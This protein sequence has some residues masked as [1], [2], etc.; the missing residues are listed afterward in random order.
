MSP[1]LSFIKVTKQKVQVTLTLVKQFCKA[2]VPP[3]CEYAA[4]AHVVDLMN[5][6]SCWNFIQS[7]GIIT[8][9]ASDCCWRVCHLQSIY[10]RVDFSL[11]FFFPLSFFQSSQCWLISLSSFIFL[12]QTSAQ[13]LARDIH[14]HARTYAR[15]IYTHARTYARDIH[16]YA[17]TYASEILSTVQHT[18]PIYTRVCTPARLSDWFTHSRPE[19][20]FPFQTAQGFG[21]S[22]SWSHWFSNCGDHNV[23]FKGLIN[24]SHFGHTVVHTTLFTPSVRP[25]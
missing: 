19:L 16:T 11:S 10:T 17:R 14:T 22:V 18:S 23:V 8:S 9:E 20:L 5:L 12:A 13:I 2:K 15:D 24:D 7:P 4:F 3:C 6:E 25:S 1:P 21:I